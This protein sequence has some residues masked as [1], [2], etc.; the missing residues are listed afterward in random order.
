VAEGESPAQPPARRNDDENAPPGEVISEDALT[1]PFGGA[2][3]WYAAQFRSGPLP[4]A[5][6]FDQYETT[7]PGAADRIL[8]LNERAM[9]L[10]EAEAQQRHKIETKI[11]D[12]NITNQS[13]GQAIATFFGIVGFGAAVAFVAT[14]K[15]VA[16]FIAVLVPLGAFISRFIRRPNGS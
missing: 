11:V 12:A 14:G 16:A 9:D 3:E 2:T 7:L 5:V 8:R 6:E 10:T 13:R 4:E 1:P 15:N